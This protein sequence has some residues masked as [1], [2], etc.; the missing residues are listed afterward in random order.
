MKAG[1]S[2]TPKSLFDERSIGPVQLHNT[3]KYSNPFNINDQTFDLEFKI[4]R[5]D[6]QV[7]GVTI[8]TIMLLEGSQQIAQQEVNKEL[9][10]TASVIS[11]SVSPLAKPE[12]TRTVTLSVWYKYNQQGS[13]KTGKYTRTIEKITFIQPQ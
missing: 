11:I 5:V 9:S 3:Y 8:T 1:V 12:V 2:S 10:E 7:S 4:S 6:P 13:E